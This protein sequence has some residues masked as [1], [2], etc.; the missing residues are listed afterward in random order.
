M[1]TFCKNS[2][3]VYLFKSISN[4]ARASKRVFG[5]WIQKIYVFLGDTEVR[6]LQDSKQ[7]VS[8]RV[9]EAFLQDVQPCYEVLYKDVLVIGWDLLVFLTK[10]LL[11][12]TFVFPGP[13]GLEDPVELLV[14]FDQGSDRKQAS[15]LD[16]TLLPLVPWNY[17]RSKFYTS[18]RF[19]NVLHIG[20]CPR[21]NPACSVGHSPIIL[22]PVCCG[23]IFF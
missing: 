12:V 18:R 22:C 11:A 9:R 10:D 13:L 6:V 4:R 5:L 23:L 21:W 19:W 14:R 8:L 7:N 16:L 1:G 20:W 15:L 17:F 2:C 3:S